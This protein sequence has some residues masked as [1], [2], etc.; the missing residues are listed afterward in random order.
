MKRSLLCLALLL[1]AS[2]ARAQNEERDFPTRIVPSHVD[3]PN[4]SLELSYIRFTRYFDGSGKSRSLDEAFSDPVTATRASRV[5]ID[6]AV[7]TVDGRAAPSRG[8]TAG[9]AIPLVRDTRSGNL[10]LLGVASQPFY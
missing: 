7:L 2:P 4:S 10:A 6:A 9:L 3:E 8:I 5:A 1:L